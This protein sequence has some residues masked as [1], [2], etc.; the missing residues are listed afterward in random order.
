MYLEHLAVLPVFM[1]ELLAVLD[2]KELIQFDR[3]R[4]LQISSQFSFGA[5]RVWFRY[6]ALFDPWHWSLF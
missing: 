5:L 2:L 4:C 6:L 1:K 3:A